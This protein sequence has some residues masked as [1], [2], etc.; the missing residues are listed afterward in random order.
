DS[1]LFPKAEGP[2]Q[3]VV[4]AN[5][6]SAVL[7]SFRTVVGDSRNINLSRLRDR[8]GKHFERPEAFVEVEH[9]QLDAA[10]RRT[11]RIHDPDSG[12]AV[13]SKRIGIKWSVMKVD[14]APVAGA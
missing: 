6:I 11:V 5:V 3:A 9:G 12:R 14:M 2:E 13:S 4:N 1:R 10:S 8:S 7:G